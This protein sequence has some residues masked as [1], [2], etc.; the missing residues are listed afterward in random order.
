M[1]SKK[2]I[3]TIAYSYLE[4]ID[5][6]DSN[7]N[8]SKEEA[9]PKRELENFVREIEK[10]IKENS[11]ESAA[12]P[13]HTYDPLTYRSIRDADG[14]VWADVPWENNFVAAKYLG[15]SRRWVI[16]ASNDQFTRC[17]QPSR[18][19]RIIPP[20]KENRIMTECNCSKCDS[21]PDTSFIERRDEI[22]RLLENARTTLT[23]VENAVREF[24][25]KGICE[26]TSFT[27]LYPARAVSGGHQ[28]T[29]VPSCGGCSTQ[30]DDF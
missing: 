1:L 20:K 22:F 4:T 8:S 27:P 17:S 16:S 30:R 18:I 2:Q 29:G 12:G 7:C 10:T 19:A 13:W 6:N 26:S 23:V 24:A 14:W 21:T 5:S 28:P 25:T 15:V 11:V 3:E 9:I